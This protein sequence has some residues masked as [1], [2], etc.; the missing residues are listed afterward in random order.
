MLSTNSTE[1]TAAVKNIESS[2]EVLK[3]LMTDLHEGKGLIGALLRNETL[4][5]NVDSIAGNLAITTQRLNRHGLWGILWS[6]EPPETNRPPVKP[7]TTPK[8][9][10]AD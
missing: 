5:T 3:N 4:A 6:H 9:P 10:F 8:N 1:I 2:T 7:L